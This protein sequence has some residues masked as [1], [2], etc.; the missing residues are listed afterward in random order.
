M[1]IYYKR[2]ANMFRFIDDLTSFNDSGEFEH[3]FKQIFPPE[4]VLK[5]ENLSNNDL[6]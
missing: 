6:S 4:L 5:K 2:F 3:N 1:V